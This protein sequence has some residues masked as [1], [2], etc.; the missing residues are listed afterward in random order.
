MEQYYLYSLCSMHL[1]MSRCKNNNKNLRINKTCRVSWSCFIVF[2]DV[3][4]HGFPTLFMVFF[5]I[6][7]CRLALYVY[8]YLLHVGAQKSAQ[9]FLSEVSILFL[10]WSTLLNCTHHVN[11]ITFKVYH[12]FPQDDIPVIVQ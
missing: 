2:E 8:E 1:S 11:I 5:L 12:I 4:K 9:T 10:N 7:S 6:L 3:N